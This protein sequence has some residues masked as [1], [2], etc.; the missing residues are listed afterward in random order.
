METSTICRISD[1][2]RRMHATYTHILGRTKD[3]AVRLSIYVQR[4]LQLR[5]NSA[6]QQKKLL[7]HC[8]TFRPANCS[9][10]FL[11]L[12]KLGF[13]RMTS[14]VRYCPTPFCR[15]RASY[16]NTIRQTLASKRRS[17]ADN[18]VGG[19]RV[20]KYPHHGYTSIPTTVR[21]PSR[22]RP[23]GLS[24]LRGG[25]LPGLRWNCRPH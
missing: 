6:E 13:E 20:Q 10:R 5:K 16:V 12:R 8:K 15:S 3:F 19:D 9:G 7:Q 1:K 24:S 14:G 22:A 2:R 18:N 21:N 25:R 17:C 11:V 4:A 23:L